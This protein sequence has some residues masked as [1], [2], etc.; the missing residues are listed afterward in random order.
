MGNPLPARRCGLVERPRRASAS[1]R[2]AFRRPGHRRRHQRRRHRARRRAA[3]T[4]GRPRRAGRFRERHVEPLLAARPRRRALPR[5]RVLPPGL[6]VEPGATHPARDRA[7]PGAPAAVHLAGVSRRANSAVEARC[8]AL[9]VRPARRIPERREASLAQRRGRCSRRS[10]RLRREGLTGGATYF[11]AS[12]ND[13]RLT[14]ANVIDAVTAG[15]A[16]LNYAEVTS[17]TFERGRVSGATVR[18]RFTGRPVRGARAGGRERHRAVDRRDQPHRES[19]VA[20][21]RP[22][23]QGRAHCGACGSRRKPRRRH[24]ARA[25]RPARDVRAPGRHAHDHR[26]DRHADEGAPSTQVRATRADVQYLLDGA[27]AYF[28]EARLTARRRRVRVGRHPPAHREREHRRSRLA[29]AASTR[30][31]SARA[32]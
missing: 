19:V 7:A 12:T 8:R 21:G 17:L 31:P 29:R 26:H 2:D 30:S 10:P 6:R 4:F 24:D 14:I 22:R 9:A 13:A 1:A 5:A 18:D 32:A 11:D 27:N 20:A 28:P 3:R 23:D 15:A 25:G 16:A